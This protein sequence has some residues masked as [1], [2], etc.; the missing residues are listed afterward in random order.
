MTTSSLNQSFAELV[1]SAAE[2]YPWI[3]SNYEKVTGALNPYAALRGLSLT[4]LTLIHLCHDRDRTKL[5]PS[6]ITFIDKLPISTDYR[7]EI[8]SRLHR[9]LKALSAAPGQDA[10][11]QT[12][13]PLTIPEVLYKLL[14]ALPRQNPL[15]D[16]HKNSI[17]CTN[18]E[19]RMS[20]PLT[21][22]G[23]LALA[24]L[25]QVVEENEITNLDTLFFEHR[26]EIPRTVRATQP[27]HLWGSIL[28]CIRIAFKRIGYKAPRAPRQSID[29]SEWPPTLRR[30]FGRLEELAPIGIVYDPELTRQSAKYE[31]T[32][33]PL[34]KMTLRNYR[35]ALS[36]GLFHILSKYNNALAD[37]DVRD[38]LKL[39]RVT[40]EVDGRRRSVKLNPLV[41]HY[42]RRELARGGLSAES[43][44]NTSTFSAFICAVRAVALYNGYFEL[45]SRFNK[46]YRVKLDPT[47]KL[48]K[49]NAKKDI[50]DRAW[51]DAEIARLLVE[52]RRI[53]K[54]RSF[55]SQIHTGPSSWGRARHRN[56]RFC[57][58]FVMLVTLR[59]MGHRQQSL[60]SCEVGRGKNVEFADDGS[61]HFNWKSDLVKTDVEL[62]QVIQEWE[63][64]TH[65]TMVEVLMSYYRV[66]Y[67]PYILKHGAVGPDGENLVA[68]QLFVYIDRSG[69][70]RRFGENDQTRFLNR[71]R[72]WSFMFM[73]YGDRANVI[74]RGL[75]PHYFRGLA[76]D[77][78]VNDRRVPLDK[79]AEYFGISVATLIRDYLRVNPKKSAA[80]ALEA[81]NAK[82]KAEAAKEREEALQKQLSDKEA[83][84]QEELARKDKQLEEKDRRIY[85][86]QD[87]LID[88]LKKKDVA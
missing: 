48:A 73:K 69:N 57:L 26:S 3:L 4:K 13:A 2:K 83:A 82:D 9:I 38:L 66:I 78:M 77:W 50:F 54:E 68:N 42:R 17:P 12:P 43:K 21:E 70:F 32:V 81:A 51:I 71:L 5:N 37:M 20:L 19:E 86:L 28:C 75:H 52:F 34:K 84:H 74:G 23:Q 41:E 53:I 58:F 35:L 36:I 63:H 85:E 67:R 80:P 16:F 22:M 6:L 49:K 27:P 59:Y 39:Q 55:R 11:V 61:I 62:D 64:Q 10:A 8:K 18:R 46:V 56:I 1:R 31:L 79:A 7:S 45:Y 72:D 25:I 60:R 30:Q 65:A 87:Q 33:A 29:Y 24:V 14:P 44:I 76:V 88:A 47:E 15:S 40:L